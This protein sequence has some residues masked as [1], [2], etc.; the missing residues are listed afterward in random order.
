[1]KEFI[2]KYKIEPRGVLHV[3]AHFGYEIV[4][5]NELNFKNVVFF[6]PLSKTFERL[7]KNVREKNKSESCNLLFVNKALGNK[8]GDIE[9][10]VEVANEGQSSSILKPAFHLTQYPGIQFPFREIVQITTLNEFLKDSEVEYNVLNIDVQGY[11]LE[12]LKG[13]TNILPNIDI[14]NSEVN[15]VYMYENCALVNEIDEFLS[16]FD[17][18]K[19]DENWM[20]Q[21][22]GD[23]IYVKK[24]F[25]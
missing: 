22:W 16:G 3:G 21:Y 4:T 15:K 24:K 18:V 5:Y 2:L 23:A 8:T 19:V 13:A 10:F 20:G 17:F 14:I 25:L 6:E 9:M 11:E 12:V 7:E 1:M